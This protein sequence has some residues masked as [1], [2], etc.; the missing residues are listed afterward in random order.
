MIKGTFVRQAQG[1]IRRKLQKLEGFAGMNASKLLEVATRAFVNQ[2]QE[3]QKEA[4]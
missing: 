3:T 1:D 2:D 4:E